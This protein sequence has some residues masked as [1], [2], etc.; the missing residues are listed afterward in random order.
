M[1]WRASADYLA[2]KGSE[3]K[4]RDALRGHDAY[5]EGIRQF[6]DEKAY[7]PVFSPY[8]GAADGKTT[9]KGGKPRASAA[10]KPKGRQKRKMSE[11]Q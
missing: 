11:N 10:R 3:I 4:A 7:R 6:I 5:A 8:V 1:S 2:A 9:A